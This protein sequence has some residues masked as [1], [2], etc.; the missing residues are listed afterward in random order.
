MPDETIIGRLLA[1]LRD[2]AYVEYCEEIAKIID[3]AIKTNF[4]QTQ[5]RETKMIQDITE[6]ING[7]SGNCGTL[8][9]FGT[10]AFNVHG[11]RAQVRFEYLE[12]AICKEIADLLMIVTV[13]DDKVKV[14][15]KATFVQMKRAESIDS[16][17]KWVIDRE[18]LYFLS[19][20]PVFDKAKG[21]VPKPTAN[22][23]LL[24]SLTNNLGLYGLLHPS[25]GYYVSAPKIVSVLSSR[26][27]GGKTRIV[28]DALKE[29]CRQSD[30]NCSAIV[31]KQRSEDAIIN[32][33]NVRNDYLFYPEIFG[34]FHYSMSTKC[35]IE[36]FVALGVGETIFSV[37]SDSNEGVRD[38]LYGLL[39]A[40]KA[41]LLKSQSKTK[42][43]KNIEAFKRLLDTP[44]AQV[45][46]PI[47]PL[48]FNDFIIDDYDSE[49]I[50]VIQVVLNLGLQ[51][52]ITKIE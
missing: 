12:G 35:F 1:L 36:R 11:T 9:S 28:E 7:I 5:I 6:K 49:G 45:R 24:T 39:E 15:E 19:R 50:G 33:M 27:N 26:E 38:F 32:R 20:F 40:L 4:E 2:S 10:N 47:P 37:F 23:H 52:E 42:S 21:S 17:S 41:K 34:N 14:F 8:G 30:M 16:P 31:N 29:C 18:Q 46:S 22:A 44:F 25:G 51:D 3:S 48:N 43:Q 13:V